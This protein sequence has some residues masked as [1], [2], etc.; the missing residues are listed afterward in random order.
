VEDLPD[1]VEGVSAVEQFTPA[2]DDS[3]TAP[4]DRTYRPDLEGLRAFA[5]III[6]LFHVGYSVPGGMVGL[7]VFFVISGFLIT[8]LLLRELQSTEKINVLR[9]YARRARRL[10]PASLLVLMVTL[11]ATRLLAGRKF[12]TPLASDTR[13]TAVFLS[14]VHFNSIEPYVFYTQPQSPINHYWSLSVEEQFYLLYP[15]FFIAL[16]AIAVPFL[17]R[18][19]R[20]VY[21]IIVVGIVSLTLS[22]LHSTAGHMVP[23]RSLSTRAWEIC[24]GA[25]ACFATPYFKRIP[26]ALATAL[27]WLGIGGILYAAFAFSFGDAYPGV[28]ALVPVLSAAAVV[29]GGTVAPR[30]GA[31]I[32][33]GTR[34]FQWLGQRSYSWYLW[35]AAVL[36]VAAD[37]AHTTVLRSSL[38]KNSALVLGG[39]VLASL[40]YRF[41]ENPIRHSKYLARNP[42]WTLIG[43]WALILSCVALTYVF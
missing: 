12:A 10:I 30:F 38:L 24:I 39:L 29:A 41:V 14:N 3:G 5:L 25:L 15:L 20:L 22:A 28:L 16:L 23:F 8:G 34:A 4:G 21:G 6:I 32:F 1:S 36:V 40:T 31:E 13:W 18:R 19:S 33:L 27:T 2:G 9:F 17:A 11:V 26:V 37:A 7:D 42:H 35:H 43:A